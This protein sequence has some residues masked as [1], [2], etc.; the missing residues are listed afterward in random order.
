MTILKFPKSNTSLY[1]SY[2]TRLDNL[3]AN[4]EGAMYEL[5]MHNVKTA[6]VMRKYLNVLSEFLQS[7]DKKE[8]ETFFSTRAGSHA[9]QVVDE[10]LAYQFE[11]PLESENE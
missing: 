6:I 7:C 11:L 1:N 8:I 2:V 10:E 3:N 5:E 4:I 9:L